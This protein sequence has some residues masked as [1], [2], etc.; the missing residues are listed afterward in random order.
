M[1]QA[2]QIIT[3]GSCDLSLE[4]VKALN[5]KVVPFYVSFDQE[6]YFKEIE[7]KYDNKK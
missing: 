2:Y 6:H 1:N 3:D 5:V 7:E 4:E